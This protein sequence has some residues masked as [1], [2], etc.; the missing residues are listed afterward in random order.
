MRFIVSLVLQAVVGSLVFYDPQ[1][2]RETG[3]WRRDCSCVGD[4]SSWQD[5]Q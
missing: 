3:L 5:G 4:L 1:Y 2:R